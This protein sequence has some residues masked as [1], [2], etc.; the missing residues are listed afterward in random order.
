MYQFDDPTTLDPSGEEFTDYQRRQAALRM[1]ESALRQ[2]RRGGSRS[3]T[4]E[5]DVATA[6]AALGLYDEPSWFAKVDERRHILI[7]RMKNYLFKSKDE[8]A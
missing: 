4:K 7:H 3:K 2:T 1:A 6:I 5:R 8:G